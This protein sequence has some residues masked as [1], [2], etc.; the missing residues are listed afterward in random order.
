MSRQYTLQRTQS[1]FTGAIDYAAELNEQQLAAVTAPPGPM[2]I[3]AGA[4]SGK[5][6]T[7]T[8]RVAYLLENGV[9]A[10]NILL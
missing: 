7:L 1:A 3:I 4:G 8:Y 5:T 10:R 9:D 6:R 2:L